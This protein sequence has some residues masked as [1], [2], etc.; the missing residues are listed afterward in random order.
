MRVIIAGSRSTTTKE[1]QDAMLN[2]FWK[3]DITCVLSGGAKGA[4]ILGSEWARKNGV[5][6]E[7]HQA[8]WATHGRAAGA[9]RNSKMVSVADGLIAVWDGL[10]NGTHDVVQKSR[11]ANIRVYVH[12]F[13]PPQSV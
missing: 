1:F 7:I 12:V 2:C 11:A 3:N 5:A 8:D 10:S 9:I 4:D 6:V 13:K